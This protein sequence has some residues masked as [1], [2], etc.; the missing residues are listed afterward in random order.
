[1]YIYRVK[2][3]IGVRLV[4]WQKRRHFYTVIIPYY[5]DWNDIYGFRHWSFCFRIKMYT[6]LLYIM[7]RNKNILNILINLRCYQ[8]KTDTF[9]IDYFFSFIINNELI[10]PYLSAYMHQCWLTI[11]FPIFPPYKLSWTWIFRRKIFLL[12]SVWESLQGDPI[13]IQSRWLWPFSKKT[14]LSLILICPFR[15]PGVSRDPLDGYRG[16]WHCKEGPEYTPV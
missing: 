6:L 1:M 13:N 15:I 10:P 11:Y 8:T 16:H 7:S 2:C 14:N 12:E 5:V 9:S 3:Y 4:V